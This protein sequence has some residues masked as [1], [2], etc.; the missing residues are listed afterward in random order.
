MAVVLVETKLD[1]G[2]RHI[3]SPM[4][5]KAS[6]KAAQ[7]YQ[8][9]CSYIHNKAVDIQCGEEVHVVNWARS[10]SNPLV[11]EDD[12]ERNYHLVLETLISLRESIEGGEGLPKV[13]DVQ[14]SFLLATLTH[15][16]HRPLYTKRGG[17]RQIK[18]WATEQ[19]TRLRSLL[20]HLHALARRATVARNPKVQVLKTLYVRLC[21]KEVGATLPA[22]EEEPQQADLVVDLDEEPIWVEETKDPSQ[23]IV[24]I[25][26]EDVEDPTDKVQ[27]GGEATSV[28]PKPLQEEHA[29]EAED[30]QSASAGSLPDEQ[31]SS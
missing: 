7:I 24:L 3:Q 9:I 13:K 22:I 27:D 25:K 20:G 28:S 17:K 11:Y 2:S 6:A 30:G 5:F 10:H 18:D 8:G 16:W 14:A 1:D 29:K 26:D 23:E 12:L 4:K 21:G 19:A 31:D 15:N